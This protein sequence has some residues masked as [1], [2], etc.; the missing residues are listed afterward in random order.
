MYLKASLQSLIVSFFGI[1]TSLQLL[2][3]NKIIYPCS[4]WC[5]SMNLCICICNAR[6]LHFSYLK[7]TLHGVCLLLSCWINNT[8]DTH[9]L[10]QVFLDPKERTNTE[11]KLDTFSSVYRRL[12]GKEVVFDYPV[13]ESAW[14]PLARWQRTVL[15]WAQFHLSE[16]DITVCFMC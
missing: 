7:S 2:A 1:C 14:G 8:G 10:W 12:C 5:F 11:N 13:A 9:P 16:I 6:M 4:L 3:Y 15:S